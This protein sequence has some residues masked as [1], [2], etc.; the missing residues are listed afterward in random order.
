M[1]IRLSLALAVGTV[2]S[3]VGAGT[4]LPAAAEDYSAM[5][6]TQLWRTEN[7]LLKRRG[8]CF[9]D[10]KAIK[11]FGNDGCTVTLESRLPLTERER[12]DRARIIL[13]RRMKLCR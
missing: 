13:A 8:F 4:T 1:T 5:S 2:L 11:A 12:Q 6:C 3:S 10:P 9:T 7:T